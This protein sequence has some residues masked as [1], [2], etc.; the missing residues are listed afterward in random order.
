MSEAA[1][2]PYIDDAIADVTEIAR[3]LKAKG[4]SLGVTED[5]IGVAAL[6][7]WTVLE[8]SH[9]IRSGLTGKR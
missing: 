5:Q 7:M 6:Y 8:L 1:P 2:I 3:Q 4:A 9:A